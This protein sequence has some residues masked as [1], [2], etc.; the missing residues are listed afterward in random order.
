[1]FGERLLRA[2]SA[3]GLSMKVLA[4][5]I[6]L[7]ANMIKKYE[8]GESMPASDTLL[9]LAKALN[10]RVEYFFR[11]VKV[12]LGEVEYRKK[13][14]ASKKQL[15]R[16]KG[17]V[18]SQ[19]ERWLDL[20]N[21]WPTFPISD[22]SLPDC[23]PERINHIDD[24]EGLADNLREEW[25]LGFDH[26]TDLI[27]LLESHGILV[28]VSDAMDDGSVDGLQAQVDGKQVVVVSGHAS[29]DRQRFTLAHELAHLLIHE[30]L[31]E[32]IDEEKAC[33]RFA[34]AFLLPASALRQHLGDERHNIEPQELYFL[35]HEFG[36]SMGACA[37]RAKQLRIIS[38][39][40]YQRLV[41][42]F[43]KKGWR[44]LEPGDAYPNEKTT[45]FYQ[46]VFRALAE[47]IV[48]DSK[49]A[50]LLGLSLLQLRQARKLELLDA[51]FNQ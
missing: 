1:M 21:Q 37:Y 20:S 7:S 32:D 30:R 48:S 47:E 17:D 50:E 35:K 12:S 39:N 51:A 28:V 22:F 29:G 11:P 16:I 42:S 43:S 41:I 26:I 10:V 13:A 2:R 18:L 45:L 3:A 9:K 24:M 49:A 19:V 25:Q 46:L 38:E 6:G 15:D 4:D 23:V 31:A 8:H 44:K 36:I 33:H 27:D 40:L 5:Q 14:S 34:S